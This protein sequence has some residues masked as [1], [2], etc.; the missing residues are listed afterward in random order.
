MSDA[1]NAKLPIR[2]GCENCLPAR[3]RRKRIA[4]KLR[5]PTTMNRLRSGDETRKI[6]KKKREG[7][8]ARLMPSTLRTATS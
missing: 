3:C 8:K 1:P 2:Q 4:S 6:T 5:K 7:S